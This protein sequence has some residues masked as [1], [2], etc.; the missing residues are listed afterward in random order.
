M[1]QGASSICSI[2]SPAPSSSA[3]CNI[4]VSPP[5]G[6]SHVVAGIH[7]RSWESPP[8]AGT[9]GMGN[10]SIFPSRAQGRKKICLCSDLQSLESGR[11]RGRQRRLLV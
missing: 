8:Q 2:P 10:K 4:Q 1:E 9:Q 11:T 3:R 6:C 5:S 7:R